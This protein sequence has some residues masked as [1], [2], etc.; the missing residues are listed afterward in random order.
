MLYQLSKS[1]E[2]RKKLQNQG[3]GAMLVPIAT[4]CCHATIKT[5][6]NRTIAR[7]EENS[8]EL[9]QSNDDS[10]PLAEDDSV[11]G[12]LDWLK[13]GLLVLR[14]VRNLCVG[15]SMTQTDLVERG[16]VDPIASLLEHTIREI[17]R[18]AVP[19]MRSRLVATEDKME[20]KLEEQV[21]ILTN[22]VVA[23]IFF[24][25]SIVLTLSYTQ[26]LAPP[27]AL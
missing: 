4:L 8:P 15:S 2:G 17:I 27:S 11:A 22:S 1:P 24:L 13:V 10:D 9:L 20:R 6:F 16:V 18:K 25:N 14:V 12:Y 21:G 19:E 5:H 3:A 23:H 7:G 26:Q